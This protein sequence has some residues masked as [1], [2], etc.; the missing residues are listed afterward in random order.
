MIKNN[1]KEDKRIEADHSF[2]FVLRSLDELQT[3]NDY[4]YYGWAVTSQ[5]FLNFL[6]RKTASASGSVSGIT[7]VTPVTR[8]EWKLLC[9][10]EGDDI[11]ALGILLRLES[12]NFFSNDVSRLSY[13][14]QSLSE[15]I[16]SC[17]TRGVVKK[18]MDKKYDIPQRIA[19]A[20]AG[21]D[22]Q[23]NRNVNAA[24]VKEDLKQTLNHYLSL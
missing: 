12:N 13:W 7:M 1:L 17:Q 14:G 5:K 3:D 16:N 11:R 24:N 9:W 4:T 2:K 19:N 6:D 8:V 23:P 18:H 22:K 15:L 10:N 21:I 20:I